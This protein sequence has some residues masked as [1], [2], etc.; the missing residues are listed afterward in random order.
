MHHRSW[1]R[2]PDSGTWPP[3]LSSAHCL[4]LP[5]VCIRV[6]SWLIFYMSML[7][8]VIFIRCYC[9]HW[10]VD[11]FVYVQC[12]YDI[13]ISKIR[14]LDPKNVENDILHV[15]F[16]CVIDEIHIASWVGRRPY[17]ISG[18]HGL[19][20][21][22]TSGRLPGSDRWPPKLSSAHCL[23]TPRCVA[24]SVV[25]SYSIWMCY[26]QLCLPVAMATIGHLTIFS[27]YIAATTFLLVKLES[28]TP[29]M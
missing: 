21:H 2:Q 19:M 6:C 18:H 28:L 29:K 26:W 4:L 24:E 3:K 15:S 20:H 12:S 9:N 27:T 10:L 25:G 23:L 7:L 13:F 17:W 16:D 1:G 22:K 5:R 8:T 14:I 11:S